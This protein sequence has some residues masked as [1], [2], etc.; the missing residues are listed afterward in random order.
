M[1][2]LKYEELLRKLI[3]KEESKRDEIGS[4][5]IIGILEEMGIIECNGSTVKPLITEE[6]LE[7]I[8]ERWKKEE[9]E[10]EVIWKRDRE[11]A[12]REAL[13]RYKSMNPENIETND[14]LSAFTI[15]NLPE[16]DV[17]E[18]RK[19]Y[20][21]EVYVGFYR[22]GIFKEARKAIPKDA[23]FY[24]V[25]DSSYAKS[26]GAKSWLLLRIDYV[27]VID[28]KKDPRAWV[29]E[30]KKTDE[31]GKLSSDDWEKG[32][33][34]LLIYEPLFKEDYG[35]KNIKKGLII[36]KTDLSF[37]WCIEPVYKKYDVEIFKIGDW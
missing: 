29:L 18:E 3:V 16:P 12:K 2:L 4:E 15:L 19:Q 23:K 14:I 26:F 33:G 6:E 22:S 11:R 5:I 21:K 17:N 7:E 8:L 34:Q 28:D 25:T 36:N 10:G 37:N 27:C 35:Y 20:F 32:L 30:V 24:L 13:E 1:S 9:I 31:E